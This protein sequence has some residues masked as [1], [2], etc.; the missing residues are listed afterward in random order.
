[1]EKEVVAALIAAIATISA[2][3][4]AAIGAVRIARRERNKTR[5]QT[6]ATTKALETVTEVQEAS[7]KATTTALKRV[8]YEIAE[9]TLDVVIDDDSGNGSIKRQL[10]GIQA[11]PGEHLARFTTQ[12]STSGSFGGG[13]VDVSHSDIKKGIKVTKTF[14]NPQ[15]CEIEL[16]FIGGLLD[17][18]PLLDV[19][20]TARTVKAHLLREA[21]IAQVYAK[22]RFTYEYI[23]EQI[24]SEVHGLQIAVTFPEGWRPPTYAVAFIFGGEVESDDQMKRLPALDESE[25]NRARLVIRRPDPVRYGIYWMG[26]PEPKLP[27]DA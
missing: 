4:I 16:T 27:A 8:P 10:L 22:D 21:E 23:A 1:M 20:M 9:V 7:V 15:T 6:E 24:D 13:V 12:L 2:A 25:A 3:L 26:V 17:T 19:I 5:I 18:D 14:S 11:R